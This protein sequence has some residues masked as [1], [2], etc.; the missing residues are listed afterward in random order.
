LGGSGSHAWQGLRLLLDSTT[1]GTRKSKC[2]GSLK[3]RLAATP[4]VH[5]QPCKRAYRTSLEQTVKSLIPCPSDCNVQSPS[6][7]PSC[8]AGVLSNFGGLDL[9]PSH[10]VQ[11]GNDGNCKNASTKR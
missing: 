3:D 9:C 4:A 10:E 2:K 1:Y 5:G 11:G 7:H 6:S 8:N